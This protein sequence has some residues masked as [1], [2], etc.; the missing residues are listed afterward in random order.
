VLTYRLFRKDYDYLATCLVPIGDQI[1]MS[2]G[3]RVEMLRSK[4]MKLTDDDIRRKFT[5]E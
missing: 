2:H 4:T 5:K 1:Q 3:E